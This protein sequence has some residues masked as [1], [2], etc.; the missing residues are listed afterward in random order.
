LDWSNPNHLACTE[1]RAANLSK[2]CAFTREIQRGYFAIAKHHQA[3]VKRRAILG[4][5]Q[6][7]FSMNEAKVF[8]SRVWEPC[9]N[10][11][12]PFDEIF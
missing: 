7:G 1:I 10:D 5:M 3:C 12:A 2:E 4:I 9:F 11:T 6:A 8:I